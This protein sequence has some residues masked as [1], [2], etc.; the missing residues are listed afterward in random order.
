METGLTYPLL[1]CDPL[2]PEFCGYP[3]PSNVY[4]V[5]DDTT[6]TGRLL[7]LG[8][9]VLQGNDSTP[10]DKSD[11]FSAGTPILRTQLPGAVGTG[12]ASSANV[13]DSLLEDALTVVLDVETGER[14]PHYAEID[15]RPDTD[16]ERSLLIRPVHRL[17]DDARYIVAVRNMVDA[18]GATVAPSP[19]FAALR[20]N[21]ESEEPSVETRREVYE[22]IFKHL[23][24]AGW[25]RD[26]LQTAWDFNTASDANN[27]AWLLNMRDE[28][29]ALVGDGPEYTITKVVKDYAED[30][31]FQ[32]Q[33]TVRTPLFMTSDKP[34][35]LLTFGDDGL[36][37]VNP[38]QP[39]ADI[40]FEI[41]IPYSAVKSPAPLLQYGHGL[42]G[43]KD[44]IRS[45]HL[46][47]FIEEYH[48]VMF[49]VDLQ[50]MSDLDRGPVAAA[51]AS[52]DFAGTHSMWDRLHQG[53]INTLVI[54]RMMKTSFA[55]DATYGQYIKA[56]EAYYYGISQGGISGT[57]Y[58][59]LSQDVERGALGVLG[60]PYSL[61]LFRSVDFTI[62]LDLM[63]LNYPDVRAQ[64]MLVALA[65]IPWDRVEPTGFT[66]HINDNLFP[67]TQAK[68]VLM[69]V[70][71]GD[72]QV[73]TL[74]AHISARI[75]GAPHLTTGLRD[76]WDLEPVASTT[77]GSFYTEYDFGLP[78]EP[79]C[80]RPMRLCEDPHG[81]V[82]REESARMQLD[83]FLRKGSGTNYCPDG[84]CSFPELSGCKPGEDEKALA[85]VCEP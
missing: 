52:G 29:M 32:I 70:A 58:M 57:V 5:R 77:S 21:T 8:K 30:I 33:G 64:Q 46:R 14:V 3:F 35:S 65:Q 51:L 43:N 41:L 2:V 6:P 80:G 47:S 83:E 85:A 60:Q 24:A 73:S 37:E 1:D 72:H 20:D 48:Y 42:F 62:F 18:D 39:W 75:L 22:D 34:G 44:Q 28:A 67:D 82:R 59:A 69:R 10:W 36:P 78:G 71:I 61:L 9:G 25:E 66:H 17:R 79:D 13:A 23:G 55:D 19:V 68:D 12:L 63:R 56:D 15:V 7:Q 84:L 16:D 50:G 27:T 74:G 40:P 4:T 11:G 45:D 31:A 76:V 26:T 53:F 54:M 38:D 81:K 49:G